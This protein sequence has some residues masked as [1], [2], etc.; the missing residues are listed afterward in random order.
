MKRS[1][2]ILS[3][4]LLS[5]LS[6]IAQIQLYGVTGAGGTQ[7]LGTTFIQQSEAPFTYTH[8]SFKTIVGAGGGSS[9][10]IKVGD[11]FYGTTIADGPN[12]GGVLFS[13]NHLTNEYLDLAYFGDIGGELGFGGL[14]H[15]DGKLYGM[16]TEGGAN[17]GGLIYE[18]TISTDALVKKADLAAGALPYGTFT[19]H[20]DLLLA[21]TSGA[22]DNGYGSV[23]SFDPE[24]GD[25]NTIHS[26]TGLDGS[27]PYGTLLNVEGTL[28]VQPAM[29][30]ISTPVHYSI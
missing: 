1:L 10:M 24:T 9:H 5:G 19:E 12:N 11:L 8:S 4:L 23:I 28:W 2:L 6:A 22:G 15:K 17:D 25:V 7:N 18:Y 29:A 20:N 26:F 14:F 16:T 27:S 13:W 30:E 3:G 21:Y